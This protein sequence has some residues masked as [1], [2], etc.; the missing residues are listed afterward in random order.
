MQTNNPENKAQDLAAENGF[1]RAN[2]SQFGPHVGRRVTNKFRSDH[3]LP[4]DESIVR[5]FVTQPMSTML[6]NGVVHVLRVL[7]KH[8]RNI[9]DQPGGNFAHQRMEQ[10]N[11]FETLRFHMPIVLQT[12]S[13]LRGRNQWDMEVL[14]P[15]VRELQELEPESTADTARLLIDKLRQ[16]IVINVCGG[17]KSMAEPFFD[18]LDALCDSCSMLEGEAEEIREVVKS[19]AIGHGCWP[20]FDF[21]SEL[22][23]SF[24]QEVEDCHSG[25]HWWVR[26]LRMCR[27]NCIQISDGPDGTSRQAHSDRA[28]QQW[29]GLQ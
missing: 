27:R 13:S 2:R 6:N 1:E 15:M 14:G 19:V 8:W 23:N 26:E 24:R 29:T 20:R 3:R 22:G 10:L 5:T 25:S 9:L 16:N 12:L 7:A 17:V 28:G 11:P 21:S 18:W 4:T